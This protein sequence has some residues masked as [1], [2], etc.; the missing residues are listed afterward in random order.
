MDRTQGWRGVVAALWCC[1][2]AFFYYAFNLDY[3]VYKMA[4]FGRFFLRA[5]G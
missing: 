4:V 5:L 3:Y 2:V 1:A